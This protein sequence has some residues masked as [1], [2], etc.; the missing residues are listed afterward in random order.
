MRGK[1][2]IRHLPGLNENLKCELSK[3]VDNKHFQCL[4]VS[5]IRVLNT[6]P[7]RI[8]CAFIE[9]FSTKFPLL[10]LLYLHSLFPY[11]RKGIQ[12]ALS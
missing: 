5:V 4:S 1:V 11:H 9:I 6:Q 10:K 2:E 8:H 3:I 12:K 7:N